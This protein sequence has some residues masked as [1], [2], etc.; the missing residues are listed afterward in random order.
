MPVDHAANRVNGN[1]LGAHRKVDG[2]G[3][4]TTSL[5]GR[6]TG[7]PIYEI[8]C[9]TLISSGLAGANF[10]KVVN[11][12]TLNDLKDRQNGY[13]QPTD[14]DDRLG[15]L[16]VAPPPLKYREYYLAN[17]GFTSPGYVRLVADL[18]NRRLYITPTHYDEWN[19]GTNNRNP[20]YWLRRSHVYNGLF[21]E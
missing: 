4:Y 13:R 14:H 18:T 5:A 9:G 17:N 6:T 15:N 7:L 10:W 3:A 11:A 8:D 16:P 20:F 19:D 21:L 12:I 1:A 2:T